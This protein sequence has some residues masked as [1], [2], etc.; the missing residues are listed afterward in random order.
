[1]R[2]VIQLILLI[3]MCS[4]KIWTWFWKLFSLVFTT[5]YEIPSGGKVLL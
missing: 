1:M 2:I 5:M 4:L 3:V